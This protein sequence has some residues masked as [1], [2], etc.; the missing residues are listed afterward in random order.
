VSPSAV[1]SSGDRADPHHR[2]VLVDLEA[3]DAVPGEART[4]ALAAPERF[5]SALAPDVDA[6]LDFGRKA[7][8]VLSGAV[9]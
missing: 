5:V 1:P 2:S 8:R 4:A 6:R 7:G 9:A 3:Q